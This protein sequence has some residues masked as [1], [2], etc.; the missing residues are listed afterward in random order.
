MKPILITEETL[1]HTIVTAAVTHRAST[2]LAKDLVKSRCK[3]AAEFEKEWRKYKI[4]II[5]AV[6]ERINI[7]DEW[8]LS[9]EVL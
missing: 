3:S 1:F 6:D 4:S 9:P 2:M 5:N 8:C 7:D